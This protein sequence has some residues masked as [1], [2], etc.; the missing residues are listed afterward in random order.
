M[1]IKTYLTCILLFCGISAT[2]AQDK[3]TYSVSKAGTLI[4]Q[5]TQQGA[6]SIVYLKL[7]GKINAI[8]FRHIRDEFH[9][10]EILDLSGADIKM[11]VGKEGTEDGKFSVYKADYVPK[12]AFCHV[13]GGNLVGKTSLRRII[14]PYS[15][16]CIDD[17]AFLACNN[18]A[19]I[20]LNNQSAPRLAND[21]LSDT[22]TTAFVPPSASDNFRRSEQ[23]APFSVIEGE[24]VSLK[25]QVSKLG[26]LQNEILKAGMQPSKIN[27]LTIEG[28]MDEDDF[29]L[30]RNYMSNLV[31]LNISNTTAEIIPE[32]TFSQKK[33]LLHIDLPKGLKK[34]AQR[35]FSGCNK[36]GGT[37]ILPPNVTAI[38]YGTFIDCE[39]LAVVRV[40]GNKL[41]TVGD[42]LFGNNKGKLVYK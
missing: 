13:E 20:Q 10:L 32:F 35:A 6:D 34:I 30:I 3:M 17:A 26:S 4:S 31:S 7:T 39:H 41:T 42:N 9:K 5:M 2:N 23:W 24:P 19:I 28:K 36:L 11:Y 8:D 29:M 18:L 12:Y 37:I 14:L 40:S 21:A 1:K 38:E 33:H 25:V 15:I 27:Y 22:I 16:K